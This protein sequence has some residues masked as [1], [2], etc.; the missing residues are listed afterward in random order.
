MA[1]DET[2]PHYYH[3]TMILSPTIFI[4]KKISLS[5]F[6]D[7]VII[8]STVIIVTLIFIAQIV[9]SL[10]HQYNYYTLI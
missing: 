10:R 3:E 9:P 6:Q 4:S 5:S 1:R 7:H 2:I 8:V